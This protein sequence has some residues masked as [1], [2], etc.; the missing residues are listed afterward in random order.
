MASTTLEPKLSLAEMREVVLDEMEYIPR[1]PK[2]EQSSLR[3]MYWSMRMNSLGKKGEVPNDK[4]AVMKQCLAELKKLHPDE[5]CV[6][7]REYF[8]F[9]KRG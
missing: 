1:R 5:D 6:F 3:A 4:H 8:G 9:K 7:D 2:K